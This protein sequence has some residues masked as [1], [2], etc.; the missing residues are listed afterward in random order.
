MSRYFL[1]T[2]AYD[3]PAQKALF[4]AF[5]SATLVGASMRRSASPVT[6]GGSPAPDQN[7]RALRLSAS[8]CAR[9][10]VAVAASCTASRNAV[11]RAPGAA[12][13]IRIHDARHS[14]A[15]WL[16]AA[17]ADIVAVS[18]RLGHSD[19]AVT[20]RV[21]SHFV[22]RRGAGGLRN[23]RHLHGAGVRRWQSSR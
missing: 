11:V 2:L 20:L 12:L 13:P 14:H 7:A 10:I 5:I 17:G 16:I 8:S 22:Q 23:T 15:S 3:R 4:F 18:R 9:G 21:Y 6:V 1:V 19:P